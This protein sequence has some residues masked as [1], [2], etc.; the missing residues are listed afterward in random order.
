METV[1]I[2]RKG[3]VLKVAQKRLLIQTEPDQRRPVSFPL[4][5]LRSVVVTCDCTLDSAVMRQLAQAGIALMFLNGKSS[6]ASMVCYAMNHGN[7]QRRLAQYRLLSDDDS[8]LLIAQRLVR[9]KAGLQ[10]RHLQRL[11]TERPECR[12]PLR[13]SIDSIHAIRQQLMTQPIAD[14]STLLGYEG[15]AS[16]VY[17]A[18]YS[19]VFAESLQFTGRNKRPPKDPVNAVLSLTYTLVHYEAVRVCVAAGLD[20]Q[21]GVL[22]TLYYNRESLAC[23]LVELLRSSVDHWVWNMF[24]IQILRADQFSIEEQGCRMNKA[25][26]EVYYPSIQVEL[27]AWRKTLQRYAALLAKYLDANP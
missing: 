15:A 20:P 17:F 1:Y 14:L 16:R 21:L 2:D 23:D 7:A 22:H 24:S 18:G 19:A 4:S 26:R 10:Q 12:L 11:T 27:R 6:D 25:A 3:S 9:Q 8:R 13:K 5:L